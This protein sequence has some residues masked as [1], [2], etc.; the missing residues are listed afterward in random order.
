MNRQLLFCILYI[1]LYQA[2]FA[3]DTL[4]IEVD[5]IFV[6]TAYG[7]DGATPM[8]F[9]NIS[10]QDF[11][12]TN[13]GQEPS[14]LLSQISPSVTVYSDAGS[15]QGYS[16]YRLRGIDQTRINMTLDGVPLNEPE[17]QGVYFSNYPDFFNSISGV[18]IQRGVGLS[19][20][21]TASYA[22]NMQFTSPNLTDS[23]KATFGLGYGSFNSYRAFAEYNGGI[24]KRL[25]FYVRGSVLHSDGYKLHSD[26][27]SQS[28]FYSGG[29]FGD[30]HV[31]QLTGFVGHQQNQMA[32]LGVSDSL[33][34]ANPRHNANAEQEKD[35]F[36][37]SL[38]FL[39]HRFYINNKMTLQSAVYY[40]HL[41]GN[42]DFDFNNFL[43]Y[44]ST[45]ELYNYAFL[46]HFV[47]LYSNFNYQT[48]KLNLTIGINANT[49]S[50]RHLGSELAFGELYRN[51]GFKQEVSAFTKASYRLGPVSFFADLQYRLS[52]FSYE[53]AVNFMPTRWQFFNPKGGISLQIN[54][55]S[56]LYYSIGRT[57]REPTRTDIFGGNDDLVGDSLGL[58]VLG[59]TN[60]E[61]VLDNEF[62][63]R[64]QGRNWAFGANLFYMLFQNE[65]TLN[66]QFGPNGL[67]LNSAFAKSFRSGFEFQGR[68][69]P[70]PGFNLS[71][72]SSINYSRITEQNT[73]FSPILTPMFI[74]NQDVS[75]KFYGFT[76]GLNARYQS[77]SFIDFG[78]SVALD[79]YVLLNGLFGY[80]IKGWQFVLRVNNILNSKYYNQG[81]IDWDG[82]T[83]RFVQAPLNIYGTVSFSF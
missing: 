51:T 30:K 41:Q 37:Q 69:E 27:S 60:P 31:L 79:D 13:V 43:G 6:T 35:E 62:G 28:L 68:W 72:S 53:G 20:N 7:A 74:I 50:R 83:K 2:T 80:E 82:S 29:W 3:Q 17:D 23:S 5:S 65:I 14:F 54:P 8:T 58:P 59:I 57:G 71:N 67:A 22:G 9:Q 40:N 25:G 36:W 15:Y 73:S 24:R 56:T 11:E 76:V 44:P 12:L 64:M 52:Q 4:K 21:G 42:Y 63:Y 48:E 39:R 33:I 46:S 47:G 75:Y 32:W 77:S 55:K 66:G 61:Y 26:N 18:Q 38:A 45:E 81:Y 49:Y 10:A 34:Q 1:G 16:Y 70:L 78:N 19:Q